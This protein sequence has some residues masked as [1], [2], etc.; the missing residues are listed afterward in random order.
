MGGTGKIQ[1]NKIYLTH[2]SARKDESLK[3]TNKEVPPAELYMASTIRRFIQR[4]NDEKTNWAIFSDKYGV[5]FPSDKIQY[6]NKHPNR[7]TNAEF[8]VLFENFT[9]RLSAYSE[10]WFYHN[11]G[12]CHKLYKTLITS[13]KDKGL[14]IILFTH[15][16]EIRRS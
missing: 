10:I 15:L 4:C 11:P 6:Y 9:N 8:Q 13:A 16:S 2:C 3:G 1:M 14:K 5:V 12:R 7:V